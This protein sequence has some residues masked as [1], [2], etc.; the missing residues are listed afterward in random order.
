MKNNSKTYKASGSVKE[1]RLD[2]SDANGGILRVYC[3]RCHKI[4]PLGEYGFKDK[5][6]HIFCTLKHM[7]DYH[8][9]PT[10]HD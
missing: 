8:G 10:I 1:S 4:L 9:I 2:D 5:H 7:A 6:G 3:E